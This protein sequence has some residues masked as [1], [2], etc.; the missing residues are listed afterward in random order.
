MTRPLRGALM[1]PISLA[2]LL[3]SGG[4]EESPSKAP[5]SKAPRG[6]ARTQAPP[7]LG[8]PGAVEGGGAPSGIR[9]IMNRVAKGPNSLT[10][11]LGR[12]LNEAQPPWETIQGQTREFAQLAAD[13]GKHDPPKG[14]KESWA[15]LTAAYAGT[16]AELDKAAQARAKDEAV[17]AHDQLKNSCMS[18]HREHRTMG[19]GMGGPPGF[20]PPG[21][22][23]PPGRPPL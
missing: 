19:R 22:G 21:G 9:Q 7:P 2:V 4:C 8:G 17:A 6:V 20:G 3:P 18:C 10:S 23:P 15:R 5:T 12:E 11:V 16:A 13:M 1:L 14:S